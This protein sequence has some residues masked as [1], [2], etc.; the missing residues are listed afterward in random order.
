[1]TLNLTGLEQA[2]RAFDFKRL[3]IEEL[4]WDRHQQEIRLTLEHREYVLRA[5][6]E[7][8]GMVALVCTPAHPDPAAPSLTH[9]GRGVI[10]RH[11]R[12]LAHEHLIVFVDD[13]QSTQV[14]QW[15]KREPGGALAVREHLYSR[16][17]RGTALVQKL[18]RLAVSLQE[19]ERVTLLD[20]ASRA[21]AAFDVEQRVTKRFYDRF[22]KE[23]AAFLQ[24]I[25]GIAGETS[26]EWYASLML[27]RLMFIYFVQKKGFLDGDLDYLR[28][29]MARVREIS[30]RNKFHSFYRTFLLRLFHDGL[31]A[32]ERDADLVALVG[33]VP[34]LNGGL[35]EMHALE[36][37]NSGIEI[38]DE[39]FA[40]LFDFFDAYQWH[41]DSRPVHGDNE[42]NPDVI[43]YIFEK[44]I[45]QKELGAYYTKEDITGYIAR[46]TVLPRM[47]EKA[48]RDCDIAFRSGAPVWTQL[49]ENPDRYMFP[50]LL[51]G[52]D[53]PLPAAIAKGVGDATQRGGWNAPVG[54]PNLAF[55]HETWRE[56][57]DRRA[58]AREVR[59]RLGAGDVERIEDLVA[60]NLNLEQFAL[61][62]VQTCEGPEVLRAFYAALE[63]LTVLDPTCG[64][65]A[66]LFA[67]VNILEPL[68]EACLDRMQMFLADSERPGAVIGAAQLSDFA[69]VLARVN[70]HPNRRYF[71]LKTIMIN[72][73][74]GVD[75]MK[76]AVEICK[77]RLFLK[78][79]SQAEELAHV[80]PLPDIDF[81]I[82]AG[83][84]LVGFAS[85]ADLERTFGGRLDFDDALGAFRRKAEAVA[86]AYH[87]YQKMQ[88]DDAPSKQALSSTKQQLHERL[89]ALRMELDGLLAKEY[90]VKVGQPKAVDA[91]RAAHSPFHWVAEFYAHMA[92]GGF[93]VIVGNPPYIEYSAVEEDYRVVGYSTEDCGNLYAFATERSLDLLA[94]EG[95]LGFIIPVASV[96]TK[97]YGSLQS[98]L[99]ARANLVVST[100][101][102][103]P[104]KLFD[105]L[106]HIRLA[107]VLAYGTAAPQRQIHTSKYNRW[108]TAERDQLFA[109]LRFGD[110]SDGLPAGTLTKIGSPIEKSIFAK[111]Q[112]QA[113]PLEFFRTKLGRHPIHFTRKLSGFVQVLD[114]VPK[115]YANGKKQQP[116]ELKTI[117]FAD[118]EV[119][120][121]FLAVLNSNMFFWYLSAT[122]DCR[123][124][125]SGEID[126]IRLDVDRIDAAGRKRLSK[127]VRA[128]MV[129][130]DANSE[131]KE[132]QYK[133]F[134]KRRIQ[135]IFPKLSKPLIDEIDR[136]L[137]RH[138]GFTAEEVDFLINY[139]LKYRVGVGGAEEA[140]A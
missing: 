23:H 127:M 33:K 55:E 15:V 101:N 124:L 66:F 100:F 109:C 62:A 78:L 139:D 25:R 126:A 41:L 106:E 84:T 123:N 44:Y 20:V 65:G 37:A 97:G 132:I 67:A 48:R 110:S 104:G 98:L 53:L 108:L 73:L 70:R 83:N 38:P 29:R 43:G 121:A 26:R 10:E 103:R 140:E 21:R 85:V 63:S 57:L 102:D 134:G 56:M 125:N 82:R 54:D 5:A 72:N 133:K 17:Q 89:G 8:R 64:S 129:D 80:E 19:E 135:Y 113:R 42:I 136:E 71:V 96:C 117:M 58:T 138:Y 81:N 11:V 114:F 79:M 9:A 13:T 112:Q 18:A 116:S 131:L 86:V 119:R 27:N 87:G 61:D 107:I 36:R 22:K 35:F 24:F 46:S 32:P 51:H 4:G 14:W 31:G 52:V 59:A 77:L 111:I 95:A 75:L 94:P 68:Y 69:A 92:R 47:L 90:G 93:D 30:G 40:K 128:L 91:W 16:T 74:F 130:L 28:N 2:V 120:D 99:R 122:S 3:F 39:A 88:T 105:G 12:K 6:A 1:M 45:N 34:Y 76:E 118:P 7:K 49:R 115:F 50:S 60:L 137:A